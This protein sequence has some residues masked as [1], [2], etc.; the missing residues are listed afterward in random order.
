CLFF[1]QAEDGIRDFHV[2]GVQTCALP[3]CSPADVVGKG[4]RHAFINSTMLG[5]PPGTVGD[6][7]TINPATG[8]RFTLPELIAEGTAVP[9]LATN[10]PKDSGQFGLAAR[11]LP[12]GSETEWGLYWL[13]YHDKLPFMSFN[14][15]PARSNLAGLGPF[16]DY[17]ED[18]NVFGISANTT[19]GGWAV[20]AE[21]SYRPKESVGIDPTVPLVGPY[22]VFEFPGKT[23]R[24]FV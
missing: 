21:L 19:L 14:F 18:R 12:E 13:R 16:I 6:L 9:L 4:G 8:Q 23:V 11:W 5:L 24:G 1:F 17:G 2:T 20:G 22:S 7:G 3:I 10:E 15:D